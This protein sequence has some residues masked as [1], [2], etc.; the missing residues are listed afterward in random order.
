[1]AG[2]V[3]LAPV[4]AANAAAFAAV[5]HAGGSTVIAGGHDAVIEDDDRAHFLAQAVGPLAHGEGNIHEIFR[6]VRTL[7][8][9]RSTLQRNRQSFTLDRADKYTTE[10]GRELPPGDHPT[11]V[12]RLFTLSDNLSGGPCTFRVTSGLCKM[13][14]K[15]RVENPKKPGTNQVICIKSS[16]GLLIH[17]NCLLVR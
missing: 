7:I 4:G 5:A 9:H 14:R 8:R 6:P 16:S 11:C 15:L 13:G 3:L 12:Q 1:G 2:N 17:K 10:T